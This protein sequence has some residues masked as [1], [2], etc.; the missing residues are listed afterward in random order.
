MQTQRE[1]SPAVAPALG[2]YL[3]DTARSVVRFWTRHLF[4]LAPV[5][6]RLA[7]AA[8]SVQVTEPLTASRLTAEIDA[9]SFRS[10]NPA[11]DSSVRSAR[12]LDAGRF[13]VL[14]FTA[15]RLDGQSLAGPLTVR[16]VSRPV[17][18]SAGLTEIEPGS[19]TARARARIDRAEFGIT[20]YRGLAGRYLDITVEVRCVRQ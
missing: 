10:G 3:I 1:P 7:F 5:R 6:G 16:D 11:R 9:A 18:W 20:G 13:P 15:D 17:T 19:F 14:A 12:L 8:G 2:T 4:G